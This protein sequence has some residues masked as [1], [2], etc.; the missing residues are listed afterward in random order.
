MCLLITIIAGLLLDSSTSEAV[1]NI[2]VSLLELKFEPVEEEEEEG[3]DEAKP[4]DVLPT[5]EALS[6]FAGKIEAEPEPV[7]LPKRRK[8]RWRRKKVVTDSQE[9]EEEEEETVKKKKRVNPME[10]ATIG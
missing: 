2:P 5:E 1:D 8:R 7:R 6:A 3:V 4:E 10:V 9:E